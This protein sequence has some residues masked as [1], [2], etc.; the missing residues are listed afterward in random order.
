MQNKSIVTLHV[1][2][3]TFLLWFKLYW[4]CG[5]IASTKYEPTNQD[6]MDV[7]QNMFCSFCK[8]VCTNANIHT[9]WMSERIVRD[10]QYILISP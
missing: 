8:S 7:T 10:I 6:V 9:N 1:Y 2:N 4:R 5:S 3:L